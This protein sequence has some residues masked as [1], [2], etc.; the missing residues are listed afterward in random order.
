VNFAPFARAFV[1]GGGRHAFG[2]TGGGPSIELIDA[3][4]SAG[5]RYVPVGHETTAALMAGAYA[6]QAGRPALAVTI[7]GPGFINLV[8]GLLCN[9]YEGFPSIS[10]SESY[11]WD[12]RGT[13][14][15]KWL[16][17]R[18]PIGEFARGHLSF[19][20]DPDFFSR[21]WTRARAGASGP[22][23]VDIGGEGADLP[24]PE[25]PDGKCAAFEACLA[26]I[27]AVRRPLVVC[28]SWCLDNGDL[29]PLRSLSLPVFTTPAAKGFVPETAPNAAGVLSGVGKADAPERTLL[30][31]AELVV[32]FGL[33]AGELLETE[34][35]LPQV[36]FD[37]PRLLERREFPRSE[38]AE[39]P[40]YA[41]PAELARVIEALRDRAWG[42]EHVIRARQR[43]IDGFGRL[44]W[45]PHRCMSVVQEALPGA[46]HVLDTGN[47]TVLGEHL[48]VAEDFRDVLG[49][50][51]GRFLGMGV[52]Y[53]LG[54]AAA[55]PDRPV[56]L[57]I[58]DGGVRAFL[59]ELAIAVDQRMK[60]CACVM[61]DG[62]YGSIRSR[63]ETSRLDLTPVT[64]PARDLAGVATSLGLE[65][66][67][68][69][70][71]AGFRTAL[72]SFAS[73]PAPA[74][75]DCRFDAE[76]Y[77]QIASTLR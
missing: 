42:G 34:L 8:P 77:M 40:C 41:P 55:T 64:L 66:A 59:S 19:R 22:V 4:I 31:E 9:A 70:S 69:E 75:V 58:G 48:L 6:R 7:K 23:H 11:A 32:G 67:A 21:C 73:D 17:H 12:H 44:E 15:H 60:L 35:G 53:A 65:F 5:V 46:V 18:I 76:S 68:V 61:S 45:S 24:A 29:E 16:D 1:D 71:V 14:K 54:A 37:D 47:F 25:R 72:A 39:P 57:W 50:P 56:V 43:M 33:R 20:E 62:F 10:L 27:E 49:T 51:N 28:G 30:A 3:L 74:V 63:A 26:Q 2:V 38:M 52:G 13:R 36:L